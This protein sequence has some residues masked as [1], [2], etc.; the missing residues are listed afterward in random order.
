MRL[1]VRLTA[2]A[3]FAVLAVFPAFAQQSPPAQPDN[4]GKAE[5]PAATAEL[6]IPPDAA[7][8]PN[9]VKPTPAVLAAAK[10]TWGFDCA[11]CHGADGDGKGDLATDMKL[12]LRDYRDPD[13]LKNMTDGELFWIINKGKGQMSGEEGRAKPPEI[14]G[15][16]DYVRSFSKKPAGAAPAKAGNK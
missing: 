10:R 5:P 16:V 2:L 8:K 7:Q 4:A 6:T 14:W 13:A 15:L 3:A 9:P 11:M 12:T 1:S